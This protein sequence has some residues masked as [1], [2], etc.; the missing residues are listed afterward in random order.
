MNQRG[1]CILRQPIN[2]CL[3]AR[4]CSIAART[5]S[6][7]LD[8]K[9]LSRRAYHSQMPMTHTNAVDLD[10]SAS[11]KRWVPAWTTLNEVTPCA[12]LK[13]IADIDDTVNRMDR[14][15]GAMFGKWARDERNL[16]ATIDTMCRVAQDYGPSKR[17]TLAVEWISQTWT[18][19]AR[20][21]LLLRLTSAWEPL[22]VG[23][24][25]GCLGTK[26]KMSY[27]KELVAALLTRWLVRES[28]ND[29]TN[30]KHAVDDQ[31]AAI[32]F[33]CAHTQ[34]WSR[35]WLSRLL[36]ELDTHVPWSVKTAVFR[37]HRSRV[38]FVAADGRGCDSIGQVRAPNEAVDDDPLMDNTNDT[39][40][41][42]VDLQDMDVDARVHATPPTA[43][44]K[45]SMCMIADVEHAPIVQL[46]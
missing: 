29:P 36:L 20:I 45:S 44:R 14:R 30:T 12:T 24:L 38:S 17:V 23:Q 7:L 39:H 43:R 15:Y 19:K 26:W 31:K 16:A 32:A 37:W 34:G 2:A 3:T 28:R 25:S 10:V 42:D 35:S 22:D 5:Y 21:A 1:S 13:T 4:A 11:S 40:A 18:L 9:H 8:H 33:L 46:S 41:M 6:H 27:Q